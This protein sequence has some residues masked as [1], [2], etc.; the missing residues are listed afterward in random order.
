M[1]KPA[2]L[3]LRDYLEGDDY[4]RGAISSETVTFIQ[5]KNLKQRFVVKSVCHKLET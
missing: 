4:S 3:W 5:A 2:D 1:K